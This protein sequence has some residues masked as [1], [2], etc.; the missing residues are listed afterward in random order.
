MNSK[1]PLASLT[2]LRSKPEFYW[3]VIELSQ[4]GNA[5]LLHSIISCE[6]IESYNLILR[7]AWCAVFRSSPASGVG[8]LALWPAG[9]GPG[10][11]QSDQ[12][13]LAEEAVPGAGRQLRQLLPPH[14]SRPYVSPNPQDR[15]PSSGSYRV[16]QI[17]FLLIAS[18]GKYDLR[19]CIKCISYL[20]LL[21]EIW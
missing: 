10:L 1:Q 15:D 6:W 4:L 5:L 3:A 16:F 9:T 19:K 7:P 20:N 13:D 2:W 12:P 11:H 21:N 18:D 8:C 17:F 14:G